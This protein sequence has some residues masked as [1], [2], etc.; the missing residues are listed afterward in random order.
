MVIREMDFEKIADS[1]KPDNRKRVGLG[2]LQ[3]QEGVM[4]SMYTNSTGQI[5]L[6][7]Q[8]LVPAHEA[9]LYKNP[10]AIAS[11]RRGLAQAAQGEISK[12]D[13]DSL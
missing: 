1:I 12:L 8:M 13:V 5:L 4:Y 9:W 3:I 10:K 7:P 2:K 6:D 11:V